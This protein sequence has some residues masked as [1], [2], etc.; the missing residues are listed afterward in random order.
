[1]RRERAFGAGRTP[2]AG[3]A[4]SACVDFPGEARAVDPAR[5]ARA[6]LGGPEIDAPRGDFP[7]LRSGLRATR[8]ALLPIRVPTLGRGATHRSDGLWRRE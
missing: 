5:I 6:G 2:N 8:P 3:K 1:M 7:G 4:T